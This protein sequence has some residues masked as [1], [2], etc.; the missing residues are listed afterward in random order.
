MVLLATNLAQRLDTALARRLGWVVH[1]QV[2][3]PEERAQIWRGLLP[4]TVPGAER[5]DVRLLAAAH[6][7][8]GAQIRNAVFRAAFR[9]SR[10][11][12][13]VSLYL[14]EQAAI[15]E[16]GGKARLLMAAGEA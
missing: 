10:S 14:L 7:L 5:V 15:E 4:P 1:F 8:T 6:E 12:E 11:G 16:T 9:A 3:G 13:P 2:P